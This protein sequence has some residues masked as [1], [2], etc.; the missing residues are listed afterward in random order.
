MDTQVR[1]GKDRIELGKD[2]ANNKIDYIQEEEFEAKEES[3]KNH[4]E[5]AI[6]FLEEM[7]NH[8]ND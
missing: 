2:S 8:V 5:E 1:L 7:E 4:R 3:Q 6:S